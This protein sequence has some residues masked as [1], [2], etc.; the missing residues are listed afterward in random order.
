MSF[1]L[2]VCPGV[3]N[4]SYFIEEFLN[5]AV[6]YRVKEHEHFRT[7]AR[8]IHIVFSEFVPISQAISKAHG[9]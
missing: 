3:L 2:L 5:A 6:N 1:S 4:L 8:Q 9:L 7:F